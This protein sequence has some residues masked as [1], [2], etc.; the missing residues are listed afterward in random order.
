[1]IQNSF[2]WKA[3]CEGNVPSS[4]RLWG[5]VMVGCSQLILIA[6]TV[7]SF[8]AGAGIT[9]VLKDLIELD[10]IV[11]SSLIGLTSVTRMFGDK[12]I[13]ASNTNTQE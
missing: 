4:K 1:M 13:T 9:E 6:A 8:I 12:S 5:G 3:H 10:I 7:L 11:G 2:I